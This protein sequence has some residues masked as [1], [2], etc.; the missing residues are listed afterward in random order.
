V[1]SIATVVAR[2]RAA[3]RAAFTTAG[4]VIV[5]TGVGALTAYAPLLSIALAAALIVGLLIV[6]RPDTATLVALALVYSNAA[7]VGARFHGIPYFASTTIPML[8]LIPLAYHIVAR[9]EPFVVTPVLR[10]L[11][12]FLA[13]QIVGTLLS[14]DATLATDELMRF[15]T[16][17]VILFV[18][19]SQAIRTPAALRSAVWVLLVVGGLLGALSVYQQVTGTFSTDYFGFAQVG[20]TGVR[21]ADGTILQEELQP[22]LEGPIGE[23]NRYAQMMLVLVPLGIFRIL[24]ERSVALRL[25]AIVCTTLIALA[26]IL[27]FSRGAALGFVLVIVLMAAFRYVTLRQLTLIGL[28]IVLLLAAMPGYVH[29]L[30][31]L[32]DLPGAAGPV[33]QTAPDT[34]IL[35]RTSATLA[36]GVAF[37]E[38]PLFGVGPGLFPTYYQQYAKGVAGLA[39]TLDYEAHNL[40]LGIAAETGILGA[41]CFLG[42]LAVV[43]ARLMQIRRRWLHERPEVANMATAFVLAILTYMTTGLFLHL[44][45]QRY[46]WLLIALATAAGWLA[47]RPEATA[48]S[49]S[50]PS[51]E[52]RP[53]FGA[54]TRR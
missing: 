26:V 17:G 46:L 5:A 7:V 49:E 37:V 23:K 52:R 28:G 13:V 11:L 38:H 1:S 2:P 51:G 43:L 48:A 32:G 14:R 41:A 16:E 18:L 30:Q 4:A 27:T 3:P 10:L 21:T 12:A 40:Y 29:R 24:G 47:L 39:G 50:A 34:S 15:L 54:R 19:V 36:A 8:V 33:T 6:I 35:I 42:I 44:S 45:Y 53:P 20:E 9:R 25:G 22:R 31:T